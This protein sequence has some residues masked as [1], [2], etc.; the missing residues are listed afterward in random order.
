MSG[1]GFLRT[2]KNMINTHGTHDTTS[3]SYLYLSAYLYYETLFNASALYSVCV[4]VCARRKHFT[5]QIT[6]DAVVVSQHYSILRIL[7]EV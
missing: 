4:C 5:G 6:P 1:V 3:G 2:T 7:R